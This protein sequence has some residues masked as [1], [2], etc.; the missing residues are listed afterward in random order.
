MT[1]RASENL[2]M[3]TDP[4]RMLVKSRVCFMAALLLLVELGECA[5]KT[6]SSELHQFTAVE[7]Y[8][9][10]HSG[11]MMFVYFELQVSPTISLFLAELAKSAEVLQDYGVLVGKADCSKEAIYS[12]CTDQRQLHT[13]FLF[14]G[15]KEFL[16]LNLDTV[17]DVNSIVSEVLFAILREEVKYVHTDADLLAMEKSA[18]GQKDLVLGYVSSLGTQEHRSI[19]E[20][21]YV[22]GSKYQFILIT[23][24]PVLKHLGINETSQSSQV[25]FLHCQRHSGPRLTSV[26]CPLTRMKKPLTIISLHSF[27]QLMEAPLVS[28]VHEDPTVVPPPQF[29]YQDTPQVFVFSRPE[30][31]HLD[32]D[33][34]TALAWRLRGIATLLLVHRQSPAVK[35]PDHYNLAYRRPQKSLEVKFVT[36]HNIDEVLE[37]LSHEEQEAEEEKDG[38][39]EEEDEE[40]IEL[41]FGSLSDE[42]AASVYNNRD[43]FLDM[44]SIT[45][46]TSENFHT[47]VA[48]SDLTV[49]LFYL[50]WDAVSI[51]VLESFIEIA[52]RFADS[53]VPGVQLCSVDCSEWTD[54]CSTE[55]G[56]S[57]PFPFQP[58]ISF[59]TVLMLRPKEAAQHYSGML[60]IMA[61]HRFIMLSCQASPVTLSSQ[62]EVTSFLQ[63][64]HHPELLGPKPDRMLGLFNT[65]T[66]EG[67]AV[68]FEAAKSLRGTVLTGLVTGTLAEKWAAD[69]QVELPAVLV[70]PSWG[71]HTGPTT[72]SMSSSAEELL[73]SISSALL[74]PLPEL[75]VESL[76]S[77]LSVDKGLL[78]LFV[79]EEEDEAGLRQNQLLL[80]EMRKVVELG[81][82]KMEA[83]V[84]CWIHLGRTPAG[85]SVLGS[86]LGSMPPLPALFL[87][88]S[89]STDEIYQYP[90]STPIRAAS[91]VQWLQR[92]Q[93]GAEPAAGMLGAD[94]WPPSGKFYDF[95][96]VMD[97]E[98]P[99]SAQ[100]QEPEEEEEEEEDKER[101][102]GKMKN[103][104]VTGS[105]FSSS[106]SAAAAHTHSEL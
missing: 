9:K 99:G 2:V 14:R 73:T 48:Q 51:T 56:D 42:I 52:D 85:L 97:T 87:T 70:F 50:K 39:E 95:L 37:I 71:R 94:T 79:G 66:N 80:E 100:Q 5:E 68:F 96:K 89:P 4:H 21:A 106:S 77:V 57:S 82:D 54:L 83:Y 105:S 25:W 92:I 29:P 103:T 19:M 11:K 22:Y 10:L 20:T 74:H 98:E 26:H 6:N 33:T 12:Y 31:H 32:L 36:L 62:E 17:F 76:P 40:D 88:H 1:A 38:G 84:A 81:G 55:V 7:F 72:L 3:T 67:V 78:L 15:G 65:P 13:A 34:A 63:E 90:P 104:E 53:E 28:E 35:T 47:V 24:G 93:D 61:L 49:V 27:L 102:K 18:R 16:G 91:V 30:T 46:L 75:T 69:Q 8:D 60:G 23:G 59:P 45:E 44:D 101:V 64:V 43:T 58:I 41:H 86:Y